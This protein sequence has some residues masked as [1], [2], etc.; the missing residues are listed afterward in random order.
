VN[1]PVESPAKVRNQLLVAVTKHKLTFATYK[2]LAEW[3]DCYQYVLPNNRVLRIKPVLAIKA[4]I[5][6]IK[7]FNLCDIYYS[8]LLAHEQLLFAS[9]SGKGIVELC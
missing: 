4:P 7:M 6:C 8:T 5:D 3:L 9:T 2:L 1:S